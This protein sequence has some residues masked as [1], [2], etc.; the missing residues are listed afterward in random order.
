MICRGSPSI[1]RIV[2]SRR[3]LRWAGHI[4]TVVETR[5]AHRILV[6]RSTRKRPL[7]KKK[8]EVERG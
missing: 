1:V 3:K 5:N 6:G 7:G 4:A 2:K 8:R